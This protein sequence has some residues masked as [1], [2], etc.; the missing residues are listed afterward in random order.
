MTISSDKVLA[1][2]IPVWNNFQ[3]TKKA[4]QMLVK[5][6]DNHKIIVVDNGS[7][8]ET[9]SLKSSQNIEIIRNNENLYFAK[10]C[11]QGFLSAKNQNYQNVMFLNNDIRVFGNYDCWTAPLIQKA[12]KGCIVGP[13]VG[14]FSNDFSFIVYT[15][16]FLYHHRKSEQR[17]SH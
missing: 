10:A 5:L 13:T 2:V 17:P 7:T 15:H 3:Y 4:I 1:I 9:K 11:N 8:D 16:V 14:C 12:E 6:P